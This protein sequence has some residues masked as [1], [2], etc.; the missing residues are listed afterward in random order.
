MTRSKLITNPGTVAYSDASASSSSDQ[1]SSNPSRNMTD[2]KSTQPLQ[3]DKVSVKLVK[4]SPAQEAITEHEPG[5]SSSKSSQ[6]PHQ[7]NHR[8]D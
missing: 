8:C 6:L 3:S 1:Q 5:S 4:T 7:G 2:E